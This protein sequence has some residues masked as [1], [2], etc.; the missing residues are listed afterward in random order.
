MKKII[1]LCLV[2]AML[3]L[4]CACGSSPSMS[5]EA[6]AEEEKTE[7]EVINEV[8]NDEIYFAITGTLEETFGGVVG[9][10]A[11]M[12]NKTDK[13]LMFSWTNTSVNG[14]MVDN[15]F[16][17]EVAPGKKANADIYFVS[18]DMEDNGIESVD[19]AEYTLYVYDSNDWGADPVY[20]HE[21]KIIKDE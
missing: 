18:S 21:F 1:V 17:E 5:G 3:F 15:W 2:C 10:T 12:E 9:F 8:D 6:A 16:A 19:E 7:A 13:T 11:Y 20:E 14:F 4:M